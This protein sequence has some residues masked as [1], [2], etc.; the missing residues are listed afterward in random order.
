MTDRSTRMRLFR[1]SFWIRWFPT[2]TRLC[3]GEKDFW[4]GFFALRLDGIS[5]WCWLE[6]V[7]WF[8]RPSLFLVCGLVAFAQLL[9]FPTYYQILERTRGF[10]DGSARVMFLT[11][12]QILSLCVA[13]L[14]FCFWAGLTLGG[15]R[16]KHLYR[17]LQVTQTP[18]LFLLGGIVRNAMLLGL[19]AYLLAALWTLFV[20]CGLDPHALPPL[21]REYLKYEY[22]NY[23]LLLLGV[24]WIPG[25]LGI[26]F[27]LLVFRVARRRSTRTL[28]V[29]I[30]LISIFPSFPYLQSTQYWPRAL[31][32]F[33]YDYFGS[34]AWHQSHMIL[35]ILEWAFLA[36]IC[37]SVL[38]AALGGE[39][40]SDE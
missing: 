14:C 4:H 26:A 15:Q 18:P 9:H 5:R 36:L 33:S 17:D 37:Q 28:S 10:W 39:V 8:L 34:L 25:W 22:E 2:A 12:F 32:R 30:T 19:L 13:P 16:L 1:R 29:A 31:P 20:L 3:R 23:P 38:L 27:S 40:A 7:R 24:T 35:G 11:D 6:A 21:I